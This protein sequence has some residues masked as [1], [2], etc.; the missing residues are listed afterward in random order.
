MRYLKWIVL[1]IPVAG[2]SCNPVAEPKK[3]IPSATPLVV[4]PLQNF[5]EPETQYLVQHLKNY[6]H[7]ILL[8]P[9]MALPSS[10]FVKARNRYRADS[11]LRMLRDLR[12]KDTISIGLTSSDISTTKN[13][14]ADW[15][16]MGLGYR[17]GRACVISTFR[18]KKENQKEQ[19]LKVVLHEI[20]HTLGLA[21]CANK[22][23]LMRDAE[24]GNPLN[25]E[26]EFCRPCKAQL[27][28]S[29]FM[30]K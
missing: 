30:V 19:L 5:N 25:E 9:S 28:R 12:K 24:G 13:G 10:A 11:L 27:Q 1:L 3:H 18:L 21:H 6:F 7:P 2:I 16:V 29:G 17:P 26:K 23:C 22:T 8:A 20:G 14:I 15:G 4:Q